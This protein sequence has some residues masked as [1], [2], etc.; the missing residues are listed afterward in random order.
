M[1]KKIRPLHEPRQP[2]PKQKAGPDMTEA[3]LEE[4][5]VKLMKERPME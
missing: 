5:L 4:W 2:D 3:E 1:S